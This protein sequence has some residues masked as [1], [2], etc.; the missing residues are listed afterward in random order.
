MGFAC[1]SLL[2]PFISITM[3]S[4]TLSQSLPKPFSFKPTIAISS[5]MVSPTSSSSSSSTGSYSPR[6]DNSILRQPT[7]SYDSPPEILRHWIELQQPL[8]SH[9]RFTVASY[10]ILGDRNASKHKD[11]YLNVPSNYIRWGYRKRV[12]CEEIMRWNPDIICMPEVDKYFDL[13]NTMEKAGYVGSYKRRTG[14]NVDGCATFWKP[15]KFRLLERESIGFK[16]FGLRDNVA[17]LSVFEM[18]RVESR[19]LVVGNIHVLYNPSRG[20]VKLGQIRFLSSRAQLL[21]NRW[22]NAPVVLGG[23]FNSTPQSAIYKFLSTSELNVKLYNR[24][25]LSGQRSCHPSEVLGG[26]RESRSSISVMDRVLND[27]WTDEEVKAATGTANSHLVMHPLQLN[28]SYAT[29]KGS[30]NTRDSNGEPLAT[31]YHSKFLGTVDYLWYSEGVLPIRVLDTL[32]IDILTRTGG[33]PCKKIGSD[34]LALVSEFAFSK[35]TIEDDNLTTPAVLC[36][37]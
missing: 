22:G 26:N 3:A 27:C 33:L 24:R 29:V 7:T 9:D 2:H 21:S 20:E 31:S 13:R 6:W 32:P 18:C 1:G 36:L 15:D 14:D 37:D 10:N 17:Q 5:S 34:H 4:P 16:G 11:L 8:A 23:D 19:R 25:E 35:S 28:S 12:L 30:I